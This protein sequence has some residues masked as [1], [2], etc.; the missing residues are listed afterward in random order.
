M[1][2]IEDKPMCSKIY[3]SI[4]SKYLISNEKYLLYDIRTNI[5]YI[6]NTK[7]KSIYS[8][9]VLLDVQNINGPIIMNGIFYSVIQP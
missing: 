3:P 6:E 2:T 4:L 8:I 9:G 7:V 1:N 5:V